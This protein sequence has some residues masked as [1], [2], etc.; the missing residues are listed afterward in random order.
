ME[1]ALDVAYVIFVVAAS[2]ALVLMCTAFVL[3]SRKF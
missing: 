3:M 2:T 1:T